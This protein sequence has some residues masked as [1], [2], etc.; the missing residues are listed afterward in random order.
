MAK[1][2]A[3]KKKGRTAGL[4]PIKRSRPAQKAAAATPLALLTRLRIDKTGA[5]HPDKVI[6]LRT[7]PMV[8][9]I[10]NRSGA[11][12]TVTINPNSFF[13]ATTKRPDNPLNTDMPIS[14]LVPDGKKMVLI[15]I[16]RDDAHQISYGYEIEIIN[17]FTRAAVK[18]IDPDLDVVD[19]KP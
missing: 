18:A 14:V 15:G 6:S 11:N 19:P 9:L 1:K 2:T 16:I 12:Q 10:F 5:P 7:G 8:W 4:R 17:A 3:S 13:D